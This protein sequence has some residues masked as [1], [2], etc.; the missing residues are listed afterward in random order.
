MRRANLIVTLAVGLPLAAATAGCERERTRVVPA[1]KSVEK[2]TTVIEHDV[3]ATTPAPAPA[4]RTE[5]KT[6]V[7]VEDRDEHDGEFDLEDVDDVDVDV[8]TDTKDDQVKVKAA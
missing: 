7:K 2:E 5:T 8:D 6:E 3:P 4:T 1:E